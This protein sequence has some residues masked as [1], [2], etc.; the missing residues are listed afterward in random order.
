MNASISSSGWIATARM[1]GHGL[2]CGAFALV[3]ATAMPLQA[4][5]MQEEPAQE[6]AQK[7]ELRKTIAT[8]A[9]QLDADQADLRDA[10]EAKLLELGP[11][12]IELLPPLSDAA[13]EECRMR[14][15]RVLESLG[16]QSNVDISQPTR[17][18]YDG[19][20]PAKDALN[21]I[22]TLSGN[23]LA[24]PGT[25]ID[26]ELTLQ[27]DDTPYW[28]AVDE[29]L[30]KLGLAIDPE[31]HPT[32]RL[33]PR[34]PESAQSGAMAAYAGMFRLEPI[35]VR[36]NF[37][38]RN[39]EE[40]S[41]TVAL[42]VTWEPRIS[43]AILRVDLKGLEL[44]C[45][46][47]EVLHPRL[48]QESEFIPFGATVGMQ[49]EFEKPTPAAKEIVKFQGTLEALVPGPS[50]SLEFS[51]LAQAS[52]ERMSAGDV[53]VTLEK[54]RKNR[55]LQELI[56]TLSTRSNTNAEALQSLLS[57]HEAYLV[58][59]KGQRMEFAGWSTNS[60]TE[61]SLRF[62]YLFDTGDSL[63]GYRFVYRY[64]QSIRSSSIR[65]SLGTI[66]LP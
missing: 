22:A 11:D 30:D 14:M 46:N 61:N 37:D 40:N 5:A 66:P 62:S 6:T 28:E 38:L 56:V 31:D 24:S 48:Q 25:T 58:D 35:A 54:A 49:L 50:I 26:Q 15:E 55:D 21:H 65:F 9:A 10:A 18:S 12:A 47:G 53:I 60:V 39:S 44:V 13:S 32:L 23:M 34:R 36:K 1:V 64:P 45:D 59:P 2:L 3:L 20:V 7:E 51:E 27:F 8:L 29:I 52:A 41:L 63:D 19:T 16:S 17:I 43:P 42:C 4:N 33:Q 57:K